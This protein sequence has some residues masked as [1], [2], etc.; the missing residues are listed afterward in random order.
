VDIH[1]SPTY[2]IPY[3]VWAVG[4]EELV[5]A[6]WQKPDSKL[7]RKPRIVSSVRPFVFLI[8][9]G[10]AVS[11]VFSPPL[12]AEEKPPLVAVLANRHD[13]ESM[14]IAKH[15]IKRRG[16][17]SSALVAFPM[18]LREEITWAEF[19]EQI[20]NP[21][22]KEAIER[23][24]LIASTNGE[25]D[26]AG[27][28]KILAAGHRLE[29]LVVC[30][31]V[32]L[33]I[34]HDPA[35]YD[36]KSNPY[37][38]NAVLRTTVAAV[39]SELTL[40]AARNP[41]VSAIIPNYLF[42]K[43]RPSSLERD[44][45]IP[46]G[47]LD[48]PTYAD[49]KALVDRALDAEGDGVAGRAYVDIGGPHR[50]GDDW[51]EACLPELQKLGFETDVD[52][53]KTTFAATDRFDAPILYLGWYTTHLNG[54]FVAPDFEFPAG[55][56]ALHI[57]SFSAVT[58]RSP[59]AHWA[60]P[61]VARGVTATFGNVAEPYLEFT[62]QPHLLLQALARGENLGRAALYSLNALSW[63]AIL[64]GDP[65][66]RPFATSADA[67]WAKLNELPAETATYAR[68][69]RLRQLAAANKHDEALALGL[70]GLARAPSLPL[71]LTVADLQRGT[72][73]HKGARH[74]LGVFSAL[75][76]FRA[77]DHALVLTAARAF[78]AAGDAS[79]GR[80]LTERL[81]EEKSLA[82]D[83]RLAALL[84]GAELASASGDHSQAAAWSAEHARLTAPPPAPETKR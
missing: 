9:L 63:Q 19:V 35:R 84:T 74:T 22:L 68:I 33:R 10:L 56:I 23:Q 13:L 28:L 31:G 6:L 60:G 34:A 64:I 69:R 55:A 32:P 51:L 73:D 53:K 71:A 14:A 67:Q 59:S 41:P 39:D 18:P 47:R 26:S 62:H 65:L 12:R 61:L 44:E 83:F 79:A 29:A 7:P 21:L 40:L 37:T 8:L 70:A 82:A 57:H 48:G 1:F 2:E 24:W 43:D 42:K 38:S 81:L 45:V 72:G 80:A 78:A 4:C 49:A 17:P 16:L 52:R 75:R 30:R 77:K 36:E 50:G 25:L 46:V 5:N 27:R 54:P 58:L 66:Y 76:R 15:Y 3:H 20:W 11:A